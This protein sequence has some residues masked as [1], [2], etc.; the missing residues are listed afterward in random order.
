[1]GHLRVRSLARWHATVRD[2]TWHDAS[3][4]M[5]GVS[6]RG[7][8]WRAELTVGDQAARLESE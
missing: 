1:M 8:R 3:G 2:L 5:S 6:G 4:R 7:D